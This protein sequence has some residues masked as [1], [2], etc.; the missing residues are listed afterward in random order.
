MRLGAS[1]YTATVGRRGTQAAGDAGR[2]CVYRCCG[3][4]RQTGSSTG[5]GGCQ[6]QKDRV[7]KEMKKWK[8]GEEA[9]GSPRT[10][11]RGD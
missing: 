8:V 5:T 6:D 11:P 7:Q 3:Q 10:V 4:T 2:E 9:K 1:V